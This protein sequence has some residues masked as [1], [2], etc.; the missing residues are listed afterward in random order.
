[1]RVHLTG[2]STLPSAATH[3]AHSRV[4]SRLAVPRASPRPASSRRLAVLPLIAVVGLAL[5]LRSPISSLAVVLPEAR[6]NLS[7]SGAMTSLLTALPVLCFA[8]VGLWLGPRLGRFGLH[9]AAV[10]VLAV[11]TVGVVVRAFAPSGGVLVASTLLVLAAIA[12]GNVLVPAVAKAHFPQRIALVSSIFGAAIIGGSTLGALQ[13]GWTEAAWG[14]RPALAGSAVLL[15]VM[16]LVW[17]PLLVHDRRAA[18]TRSDLT[19]GEIARV[20]AVWP[21]VVCF[22]LVSAQAYA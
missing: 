4:P 9:R 1:M 16:V 21:L 19:L 11:M 5:A 6:D 22:G 17:L 20:G 7:L 2:T 3:A 14:W 8:V 13:G 18:P 10:V 12:A 15:G